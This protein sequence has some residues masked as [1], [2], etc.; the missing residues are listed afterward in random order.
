MRLSVSGEETDRQSWQSSIS[1]GF[2][3]N[4]EALMPD[5]LSTR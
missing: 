2:G 5:Q 4:F 1:F 3:V